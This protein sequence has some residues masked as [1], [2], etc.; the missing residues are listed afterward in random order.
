MIVNILMVLSLRFQ[1]NKVKE[2]V[3]YDVYKSIR[4]KTLVVE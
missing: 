2:K 1:L 3:Y 4:T